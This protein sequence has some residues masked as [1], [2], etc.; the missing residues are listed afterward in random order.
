[1]AT[2]TEGTGL[3]ADRMKQPRQQFQKEQKEA[4]Y[5]E[6]LKKEQAMAGKSG[7]GR[8][9]QGMKGVGGKFAP[10]FGIAKGAAQGAGAAAGYVGANFVAQPAKGILGFFVNFFPEA[11]TNVYGW[12]LWG[13][14]F[15]YL[16]DWFSGFNTAA[17]ANLHLWFAAAAF[18]ILGITGRFLSV[19]VAVSGIVLLTS[20]YS[21]VQPG[22]TL[23][24]NTFS[25][26]SLAFAFII[27]WRANTPGFFKY[28]PLF[29]FVDVYALPV[30][31]DRLLEY[32]QNIN[33][34]SFAV[35]FV[36]N[37]IL[38]PL[39]LWFGI[40]AFSGE[41][42]PSTRVARKL[43]AVMIVFYLVVSAPQVA[44]AYGTKISGLTPEEKEVAQ[45]VW[46]RFHAN[47]QHI[48]S[49]EFL[50]A[51]V[52]SAYGSL[53]QTLGFGEPKQQPKLGLALVQD[54]T[55]LKK[56]DIS[57][58]KPEP[59]FVMR[60]TSPFPASSEKPYIEVTDINCND[61]KS[62]LKFGH[63]ITSKGITPTEG[64]PVAVFYNGPDG[65]AQ[66]K[67]PLLKDS[68]WESG[69]Y[70]ISAEVDYKVDATA[71]LTTA[72]IRADQD[73]ALR[74]Q[75]ID[76]SVVNNIRPAAAEYENV[77]VTLTW[78][79]PDLTKSPASVNLGE[80]AAANQKG[81][82]SLVET[83]Q[84]LLITVYVSK[85]S[86]WG[87]GEI[88][89]VEQLRLLLPEGVTLALGDSCDFVPSDA[90]S[91]NGGEWYVA[92]PKMI[93]KDKKPR[94]IGDAIR[95]D[96]GLKVSKE[97]LSG[98]DWAPARFDVSGRF[99]FTTKLDGI[100]FT[101]EGGEKAVMPQPAP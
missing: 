13:A 60:I 14:A 76:P 59:S 72:F 34:L 100:T 86:G 19:P 70:T 37:R 49:G 87:K 62:K 16:I 69:D 53:E 5:L 58:K 66:V 35:A 55:M 48:T 99:I 101:V 7:L 96:C 75:N 71:F 79:P 43:L 89:A 18:L 65:G 31:R 28:L 22:R 51:P 50:K 64:K 32:A 46:A 80:P 12:F 84:N 15:I 67:C 78:G 11:G 27:Y 8:I 77:P 61:K 24:L 25:V 2:A 52:A 3:D 47:L 68:K 82:V 94:F 98:A 73:E 33:Y 83:A 74:K 26:V 39:W 57:Y 23:A 95:F 92:D 97:A 36:T 45:G 42:P 30:F 93:I 40:F 6:R 54:S 9:A 20:L 63:G 38:F 29:A 91:G 1:M 21:F 17:T 44:N 10:A 56:Y 90:D 88:K 85:N 81:S 4:A 41:T